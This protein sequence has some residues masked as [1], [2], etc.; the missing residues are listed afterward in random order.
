MT[1]SP[2]HIMVSGVP[3]G[4]TTSLYHYLEKHPE[5]CASIWKNT[6]YFTDPDFNY[7]GREMAVEA[8]QKEGFTC[9]RDYFHPEESKVYMEATATYFSSLG[10][11]AR[12]RENLE[13]VKFIFMLRDPAERLASAWRVHLDAEM[14]PATTTLADYVA[15]QHREMDQMRLSI[16]QQALMTGH[17]ATILKGY[18]ELF[19]SKDV[20][21]LPFSELKKPHQLMQKICD[22]VGV[23]KHFYDDYN[24][25]KKNASYS[26]RNAQ[27]HF[28]LRGMVKKVKQ[29]PVMQIPL[30]KNT[31]RTVLNQ[32]LKPLYKKSMYQKDPLKGQEQAMKELR[33]YYAGEADALYE[34]TGQ[35]GLID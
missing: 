19:D 1:E 21:L 23:D 20:L 11:P 26:A 5:I 28:G 4:G 12:I 10:T 25:E 17:Y 7:L 30:I 8:A 31:G 13:N 18:Y 34:L 15:M 22:F 33:D 35:R 32:V 14:V 29:N 9:Y 16:T 27:V 24:F 6:H 2:L 3:K